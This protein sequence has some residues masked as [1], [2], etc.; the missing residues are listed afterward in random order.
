MSIINPIEVKGKID[1]NALIKDFGTQ[2]ITNELIEK[3][4]KITNTKAHYWIKRGL[5]FSHR[6]LDIFLDKYAKGEEIFIYTGRG[7]TSESLHIG[8]LIPFMFTKYLQ[9]TFKC[10]VIIQIADDEKYYFKD[11][12]IEKI[13]KFAENNIKDILACGFDL[14]N[15][16]F[17]FNRD[18]RLKTQ[19]YE[20]FVSEMKKYVNMKTIQK[21]FGF[22]DNTNV[23]CYD[24]IFYQ[25]ASAFWKSFP[26][27][28]KKE[29][30]CLVTYAIDQD[31]Y[32]RLARDI[33][34]KFNLPKPTSIISK[35]IP[36]LT[37]I[38]GKMSSSINSDASIFINDS[39]N[40]IKKKIK[41]YAFSGGGG[42]GSLEEHQ[43]FGGN[44]D[45][46]ISY[47]Y[48]LYFEND[49]NKLN[50]IKEKFSSGIMTCAEIKSIMIDKIILTINELNKNKEN[51]DL[52]KIIF[53]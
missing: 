31:P 6:E 30:Y 46:D 36:P 49:D 8:H 17:F 26:D 22:D 33:S 13:K 34:H 35:F 52:E 42:N 15:T 19:K 53:L 50:E 47:Q 9:D 18:Y 45:K 14:D 27:V 41:K 11:L 37:G 32:F 28:F 16:Y 44:I 20:I 4:E 2:L 40:I 12:S 51:L 39:E 5:F 29:A 10:K 43:K 24:W 7:P 3:F 23:G 38:E 21:I 48:L 25:T 1:Y